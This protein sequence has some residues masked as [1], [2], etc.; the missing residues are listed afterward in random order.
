MMLIQQLMTS[1]ALYQ[2][3]DP[4]QMV[5]LMAVVL[6]DSFVTSLRVKYT[7]LKRIHEEQYIVV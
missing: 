7:Y 5:V 1:I 3:D 6:F 4:V 2:A